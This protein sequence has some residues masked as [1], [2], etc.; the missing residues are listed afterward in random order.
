MHEP[1][2]HRPD[3]WIASIPITHLIR[4]AQIPIAHAAPPTYPFP[5]F[6]P[7]E[8]C[9]RRPRCAPSHR[10]GGRHP[11]TFTKAA[12]GLRSFVT[13]THAAWL[14]SKPATGHFRL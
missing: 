10:H 13:P 4:G 11:K 3:C 1:L 9:G 14:S 6:P 2:H 5:R 8:V 7:L 12:V